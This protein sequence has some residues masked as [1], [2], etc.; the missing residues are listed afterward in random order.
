MNKN[1]LIFI[2]FILILISCLKPIDD[3]LTLSR[4]DYTG[5]EL[6]TK[7]YFLCSQDGQKEVIFLYRNGIMYSAGISNND[8]TDSAVSRL[9][10]MERVPS[11]FSFGVFLVDSNSLKMES[12]I[13]TPC[14][15]QTRLNEGV[16][17]NDSTFILTSVVRPKDNSNNEKIQVEFNFHPYPIKPDSTNSF[18]P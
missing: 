14:F 4:I 9:S 12:W 10:N 15:L 5:T 2:F 6:R 16:I 18:I 13:A 1:K 3:K 17:V 7:G 11:K 8:N